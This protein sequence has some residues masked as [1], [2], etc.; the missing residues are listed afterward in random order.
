MSIKCINGKEHPN[1]PY[2]SGCGIE[3]RITTATPKVK[4]TPTITETPTVQATATNVATATKAPTATPTSRPC[5]TPSLFAS[6]TPT[7]SVITPT[8]S[9]PCNCN[10]PDLDCANFATHAQAQACHNYCKSLGKGDVFRLDGDND[11]SACELLP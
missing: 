8:A 3:R 1:E 10:G 2:Y 7:P 6:I 9:A 4:E 11:G 5:P